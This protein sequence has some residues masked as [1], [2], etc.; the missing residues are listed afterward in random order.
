MSAQP[1]RNLLQ[2]IADIAARL[3]PAHAERLATA[4]ATV[5]GP[6]SAG[7]LVALVPTPVFRDSAGQLL[8]AWRQQADVAGATLGAALAA[9]AHAHESARRTGQIELVASGPTSNVVH[10]RRT[11][12]VLL[13]LIDQARHQILLITFGLH[14]HD[15]LRAALDRAARRGVRITV[16]AEDPADNPEFQ[17]NPAAALAGLDVHRLRWPAHRR[18]AGGAALHAKVVVIDTSTALV[19]SANLTRRATGDNLEIGVLLRGEDIPSRLVAHIAELT[20]GR[21]LQESRA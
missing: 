21:V 19:T 20:Q 4:L 13:Q 11:E 7:H 6:G 10:A 8:D 9:A 14:M 1:G 16:L 17:G 15:D 5:P 12:Q 18:P 2:E 3:R